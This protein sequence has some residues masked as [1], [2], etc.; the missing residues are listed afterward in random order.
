MT[1]G[2]SSTIRGEGVH[3]TD[4]WGPSR[5]ALWSSH[6][7]GRWQGAGLEH[8][9][10]GPRNAEGCEELLFGYSS[11]NARPPGSVMLVRR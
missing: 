2:R 4:E 5:V 11:V 3:L 1:L 7:H 9:I 8:V 10:L 6:W